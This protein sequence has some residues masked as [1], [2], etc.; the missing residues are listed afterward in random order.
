MK[1]VIHVAVFS[2]F[3]ALTVRAQGLDS[4]VLS[5]PPDVDIVVSPTVTLEWNNV[6]GA[7]SYELQ[8]SLFSDFSSLVNPNPVIITTNHYQI[9]EGVLSSFTVYYWRVKAISSTGS[10]N[11]SAAWSFRTAGTPAQEI[12]S[13]EVVVTIFLQT[14]T[15][16][17]IRFKFFFKDWICITSI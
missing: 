9:P 2:L 10:S 8:I 3:L 7:V 17:L 16:T 14:I 1:R 15:L 4:P 5:E 13:L 11:Y 12:G 6:N